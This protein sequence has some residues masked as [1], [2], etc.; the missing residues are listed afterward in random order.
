MK[1]LSLYQKSLIIYTSVILVICS[2]IL[3]Y[4]YETM[5]LYEQNLPE[6]YLKELVQNGNLLKKQKALAINVNKY[7]KEGANYKDALSKLYQDKNLEIV[8]NN[9]NYDI[10]VNDKVIT[11]VKL[12]KIN[13]YRRL[14][15]L[16]INEWE[17][18]KIKNYLEDGIYNFTLEVPENYEVIINNHK[19]DTEDKISSA[20]LFD[21]GKMANNVKLPKQNTYEFKNLIYKPEI[22]ILDEKKQVVNYELKDNKIIVKK[23]YPTYKTFEEAKDK[24]KSDIDILSLAQNWSLFL[25]NDLKT[26]NRGFNLISPYLVSGTDLYYLAQRWSQSI[27]IEWISTHKLKDPT[28]TNARVENCIFYNDEAFS[29]EVYLEKNMI[30]NKTDKVDIMHDRMYFIYYKNGYKLIDLKA[31]VEKE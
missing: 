17:I 16:T 13:S 8:K 7:E 14:F 30:I 25:S 29:C 3:G 31:V 10:V 23:E 19:L 18:D 2:L 20:N 12:K 24:L 5:K 15:I 4:V 21:L 1:K 11:Q 27:D 6:N 26:T 28:F 22:T 9:D